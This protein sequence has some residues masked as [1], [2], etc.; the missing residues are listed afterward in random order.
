LPVVGGLAPWFPVLSPLRVMFLTAIVWLC[1]WFVCGVRV[2]CAFVCVV[3]VYVCPPVC[4]CAVVCVVCV[5][6]ACVL[7]VC[8][9]CVCICLRARVCVHTDGMGL[10]PLGFLPSS[11]ILCNFLFGSP[12]N[13]ARHM[14]QLATIGVLT[15]GRQAGFVTS[16]VRTFYGL[17][18]MGRAEKLVGVV[19]PQRVVVHPR[20]YRSQQVVEAKVVHFLFAGGHGARRCGGSPGITCWPGTLDLLLPCRRGGRFRGRGGR[21]W[22]G[23]LRC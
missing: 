23:R 15:G 18:Q 21:R 4:V 17:G 13:L 11:I 12:S 20:G 9:R 6:R 16:M 22:V 5:W 19:G 10:A 1:A 7:C 3:C 14:C 2:F 8:V